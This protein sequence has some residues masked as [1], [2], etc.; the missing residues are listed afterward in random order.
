[1]L[2]YHWFQDLVDARDIFR[3]FL[4]AQ[5]TDYAVDKKQHC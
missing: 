1:M 3:C 5:G 2:L 4:L